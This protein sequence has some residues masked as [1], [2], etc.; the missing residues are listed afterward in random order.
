MK[1]ARISLWEVVIG[2]W[3]F[4]AVVILAGIFI[5][6]NPL[7]Y[8]LGELVGSVTASGLMFHLYHSIDVELD[9]PKK[10]AVSHSRVMGIFR[11]GLE[12][13]VLFGS[14]FVPDWIL[15][16]TVFAGLLSRKFAVLLVPY[17]EKIRT[18]GN[19]TESHT[20]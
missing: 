8:V 3:I 15:P 17:M 6:P 13:A 19:M 11:S 4:A 18:R 5:V 2:I 16:Y 9:L 7:A 10:R 12:I 1:E 20:L 14:F